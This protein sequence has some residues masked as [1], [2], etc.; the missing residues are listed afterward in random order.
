MLLFF[1]LLTLVYGASVYGNHFV[2]WDDYALIVNNPILQT[3]SLNNVVMAFTTYDPELYIPLTLLSYHLDRII[4]GGFVPQVTHAINLLL[5][6]FNSLLVAA[7]LGILARDRKAGVIAGLFFAVHPIN[8]EAVAWASARKDLLSTLFFIFAWIAYICSMDAKT[9]STALRWHA[10]SMIAF[11]LALLS[12]VVA[13]ILPIALLLTHY[14][15]HK[16]IK[17]ANFVRILPYFFL[18]FFFGCIAI[19][20]QNGSSS[21]YYE[22]FLVGCLAVFHYLRQL[23]LPYGFSILYPLTS[24]LSLRTFS[25]ALS[26]FGVVAV[27]VVLLFYIKR[28]RETVFAWY[29][30]LLALAP[31]MTNFTKSDYF[32][33]DVYI[34]SDRY[35]YVASIGILFLVAIVIHKLLHDYK[36]LTYI[37]SALII[38]IFSYISFVQS[39]AWRDTGMLFVTVLQSNPDSHLAR[40]N[41]GV[42]LLKQGKQDLAIG[43]F[44]ESI[45]I[46][47]NERAY[48]NLGYSY[49]LVGNNALARSMYVLSLEQ[50]PGYAEAMVGIGNLELQEGNTD[51]AEILFSDALKLKPRHA[52][53]HRQMALLFEVKGDIPQAIVWYA[54]AG[55]LLPED[56]MIKDKINELTAK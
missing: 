5:H 53:A 31:T 51:E 39:S 40:N 32:L 4:G 35:A 12:K 30:F 45:A 50:N 17:L 52:E 24:A 46:R 54:K 18:S 16:T 13:V 44:K 15:R 19:L 49:A 10:V 22:K 38:A 55:E 36:E 47:P 23:I 27:S 20:G 9:R 29:F 37:I 25:I 8:T 11:T 43:Q 28:Q 21:F 33:Q 6:I 14:L 42:I 48:S 2:E 34:G 7:L 56:Q 3:T 26:V 1:V 41:I